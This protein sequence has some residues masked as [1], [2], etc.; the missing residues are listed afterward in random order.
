MRTAKNYKTN[1]G[2][3]WV[4]DGELEINGKVKKDGQEIDLVGE[5]V[6]WDTLQGKPSSFP[7]ASHNHNDLY[8]SKA[9]VDSLISGLQSQ[10]D[11]LQG[12]E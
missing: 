2:D 7:P 9:E 12:G 6:T 11:D 4:V 3:T 5:P 8:Y 10:I 1:N